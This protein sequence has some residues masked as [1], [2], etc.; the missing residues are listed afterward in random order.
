M[1]KT[2]IGKVLPAVIVVLCIIVFAVFFVHY[3]SVDK[4]EETTAVPVQDV[5]ENEESSVE[6]ETAVSKTPEEYISSDSS[7]GSAEPSKQEPLTSPLPQN[8]DT[9]EIEINEFGCFSGEY[10]EDGSNIPVKNVAAMRITNR[11][12]RFLEYGKIYVTISGKEAVFTVSAIP[13]WKSVWI[14]EENKTE[15]SDTEQFNFVDSVISYKD[16]VVSATD[17]IRL[18]VDGDYLIAENMSGKTLENITVYYKNLHSDGRF[19]G[20]ITYRVSFGTAGVGEAVKNLAGHYSTDSSE[21]VRID[22]QE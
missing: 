9:G 8:T 13:P 3:G 22:W 4:N 21:I 11:S 1:K 12:G 5:T 15:I 19:F 6:N 14:L 7:G 16:N 20:G 10:V 17:K 2:D 18:S